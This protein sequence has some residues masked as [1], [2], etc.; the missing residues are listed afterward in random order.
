[1]LASRPSA[2]RARAIDWIFWLAMAFQGWGNALELLTELA[3]YD[4][5][6]YITLPMSLAPIIYVALDGFVDAG[7]G[8]ALLATWHSAVTTPAASRGR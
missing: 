1:L 7:I 6:V 4:N 5:L 3:W 8:G 2:R